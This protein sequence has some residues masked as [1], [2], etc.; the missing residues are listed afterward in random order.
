VACIFQ[1]VDR[2]A[3]MQPL[4]ASVTYGAGG[5][6]H[7]DSLEI[8]TRM[9]QEHGLE[10]MAHLTCVGAKPAQLISFL[11]GLG[12]AGVANVLALRGDLPKDTPAETIT[13]S[14]LLYASDLV[15]FIRR[16]HPEM[17]IGVAAYP[18][19]HPE[20]HNPESDLGYLKLKLDL[21]GDFAIT[22]LFLTTACISTLWQRPVHGV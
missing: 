12:K 11:D 19:T 3:Q 16:T 10:T 7:G 20:A 4:F 14:P 6:T 15:T 9:Q 1:V 17:G 22:Q 18:E 5:S 2:L 13:E 8:V 21:G